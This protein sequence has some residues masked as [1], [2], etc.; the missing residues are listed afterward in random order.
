MSRDETGS[1]LIKQKLSA[2][3]TFCCRDVSVADF[4]FN[5]G[6]GQVICFSWIW[7]KHLMKIMLLLL[8]PIQLWL[9][10]QRG[11]ASST[12]PGLP[13]HL[14][15]L[16]W[17]CTSFILISLKWTGNWFIFKPERAIHKFHSVMVKDYIWTS[18]KGQLVASGWWSKQHEMLCWSCR[19]CSEKLL[20]C[21]CMCF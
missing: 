10:L 13:P 16:Y 4:Q 9:W 14:H 17:H 6:S 1:S 3:H 5:S 20:Y 11:L 21:Y 7:F 2:Y 18:P 12:V 19:C 15:S 8:F